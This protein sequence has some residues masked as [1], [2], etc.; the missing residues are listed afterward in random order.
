MKF[1][2]A[3]EYIVNC[4]CDAACDVQMVVGGDSGTCDSG[5]WCGE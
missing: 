3:R 4:F 1:Q 2:V 5:H